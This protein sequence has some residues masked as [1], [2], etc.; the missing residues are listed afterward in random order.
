MFKAL[1][2]VQWK[3]SRFAMLLGMILGFAVPIASMASVANDRSPESFV[4]HMQSYAITYALLAA[5][6][7]LAFALLA[8]GPDHRGR[9]VYALSLPISRARYAMIKFAS[10][11]AFLVG[12]TTGVLIGCLLASAIMPIPP[13]LHAYP[14][15]LTLRFFFASC[16]AF[17]IFFAVASMTPKAAGVVLGVLGAV[18]GTQFLLSA[19][20]V[21]YDLLSRIGDFIFNAPG[22][23][24][25]FT[26][27]WMLVDV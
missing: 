14:L 22:V 11:L 19:A 13:G 25:V 21:N 23:L 20:N 9:H 26:G 12:P 7:G 4:R 16:V 3:W 24:S 1:F 18:V 17:A 8:W 5:G 27:R 10:G 6:V 2:D 15:A